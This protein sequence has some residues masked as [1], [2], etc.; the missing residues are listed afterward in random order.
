MKIQAILAEDWADLR[1]AEKADGPRGPA[2]EDK[3]LRTKISN[4]RD[5]YDTL[6]HNPS[7]PAGAQALLD[8]FTAVQKIDSRLASLVGKKALRDRLYRLRSEY[9][10]MPKDQKTE[11]GRQLLQAYRKELDQLLT[12][13]REG[14]DQQLLNAALADVAGLVESIAETNPDAAAQMADILATLRIENQN[15][16]GTVHRIFE[17]AFEE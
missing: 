15:T 16:M 10:E 3:Q 1:G 6:D 7:T 4:M 8:Y 17:V 5:H 9:M 12:N 13:V 11:Q 14:L 2:D